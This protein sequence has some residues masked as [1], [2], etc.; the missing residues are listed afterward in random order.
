MT[1]A[2]ASAD[3]TQTQRRL[4]PLP[5]TGGLDWRVIVMPQRGCSQAELMML[6]GKETGGRECGTTGGPTLWWRGLFA[7]WHHGGHGSSV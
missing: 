2:I 7:P 5:A 6:Q 4:A 3:D 1:E